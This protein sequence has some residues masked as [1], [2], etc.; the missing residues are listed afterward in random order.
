[1]MA[2]G[3]KL[4]EPVA[5]VRDGVGPRH[6]DGVEAERARLIDEGALDLVVIGQK[7][8]SAYVFDGGIPA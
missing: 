2:G 4:R 6:R 3:E 7:S 1:M 5:R 8:R